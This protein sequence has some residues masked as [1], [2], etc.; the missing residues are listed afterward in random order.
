MG[1]GKSRGHF[2]TVSRKTIK[3][4]V[5]NPNQ[6]NRLQDCIARDDRKE[7]KRQRDSVDMSNVV[8]DRA[9]A[10]PD[11]ITQHAQIR[12]ERHPRK[13]VPPRIDAKTADYRSEKYPGIF[14]LE[15]PAG[16]H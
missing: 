11:E 10:W 9:Q 15:P 2:Q 13:N 12:C 6:R 3:R 5:S 4:D 8:S 7:P 16:M 14:E 1:V